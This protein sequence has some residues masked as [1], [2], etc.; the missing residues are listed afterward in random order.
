LSGDLYLPDTSAILTMFDNEEGADTVEK[1]MRE[2]EIILPSIV[3]LEVYY[4]SIKS[5]NIDVAEQRYA[6]L[7]SIDAKHIDHMSEPILLKAGEFKANFQI[8]LADALISAHAFIY[9][10][11]LVHKDPEYEALS[12]IDQIKLP[13]KTSSNG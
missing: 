5:R 6:L 10:A 11:I 4:T 2:K 8:S 9:N 12:M 3:L 7:K 1:I 13:Y